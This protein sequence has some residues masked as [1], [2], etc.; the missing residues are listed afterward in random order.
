[1]QLILNAKE[2]SMYKE[3]ATSKNHKNINVYMDVQIIA[4]TMKSHS[5]LLG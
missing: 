3:G 2:N 4:I 1:M 5:K